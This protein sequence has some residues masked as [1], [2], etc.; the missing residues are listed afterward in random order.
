MR[1]YSYSKM[2]MVKT[3]VLKVI[4]CGEYGVG[5]SSIFRRFI[6][7]TFVPN[8]DRRSTLGLDHFDKPYQLSD[9]TVKVI[10]FPHNAKI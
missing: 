8:A 9:K 4:L 2:A 5:K 6:N 10:R 1:R 7:N 3:P